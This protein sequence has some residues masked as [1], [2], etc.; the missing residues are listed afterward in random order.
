HSQA[1]LGQ[2][3]RFCCGEGQSNV[4]KVFLACFHHEDAAWSGGNAVWVSFFAFFVEGSFPTEPVT[5]E[6]H[7]YPFQVKES[8]RLR[9]RRLVLS[10]TV[11]VQGLHDHQQCNFPF[12]G[13]PRGMP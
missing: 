11:V 10:R 9:T 2:G 8:K 13:S 1:L 7:P 12:R 3:R 4:L 6:A 5:R